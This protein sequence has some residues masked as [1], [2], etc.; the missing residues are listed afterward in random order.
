MTRLVGHIRLVARDVH[1]QRIGVGQRA[2]TSLRAV[3]RSLRR[4]QIDLPR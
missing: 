1:L 3:E 2:E 4:I